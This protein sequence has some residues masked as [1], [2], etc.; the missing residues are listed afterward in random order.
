MTASVVA[1][2]CLFACA[3]S[4]P[5]IRE[6]DYPKALVGRWQGSVGDERETMSVNA[7]GRFTCQLQ[8]RGFIATTLSQSRPGV[9]R[10]TWRVS[11][12]V[13]TL[14]VDGQHDEHV[15]NVS[16]SSVIVAFEEN[17]LVLESDRGEVSSFYRMNAP[18]QV[19]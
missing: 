9:I 15:R 8:R 3:K 12:R 14:S 6:K 19:H 11:G 4:S 18:P 5:P 17:K 7:D 16:A 1:L 2:V 10:G 13:V